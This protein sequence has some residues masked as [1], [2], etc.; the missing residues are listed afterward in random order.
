MEFGIEKCAMLIMRSGKR[1]MTEEIEL[2]NQE[3]IRTLGEK[4]TYKYLGILEADTIKQAETMEKIRKEYLRQT[5]KLLETKFCSRNLIK[6]INTRAVSLLRTILEM[7]AERTSVNR[8][9]N[10]KTD[11]LHP[12][13]D[14]DGLYVSRK[15]G[16]RG[17]ASIE[18]SLEAS[19]R[20]LED[21][22]K[23]QRKINYSDQKQ[24]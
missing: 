10:K 24:Y 12:R 19:I 23:K 13:N 11:V 15:E 4:E 17:F 3:K 5:K 6:G 21:Y 1:Q 7:N 22:I 16:R 14:I 9:E 8:P 2:S 18:D 20:R